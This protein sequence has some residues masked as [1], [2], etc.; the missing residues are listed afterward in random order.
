M[1]IFKAWRGHLSYNAD[2]MTKQKIERISDE[3]SASNTYKLC[4]NWKLLI[5]PSFSYRDVLRSQ[6]EEGGLRR[7]Q[8]QPGLII[9]KNIEK[10]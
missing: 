1:Y 7:I 10:S 9:I 8:I 5:K 4:S 3:T 6:K 2:S